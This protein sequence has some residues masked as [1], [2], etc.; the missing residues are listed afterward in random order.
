MYN[1][2]IVELIQLNCFYRQNKL[3]KESVETGYVIVPR[4]SVGCCCTIHPLSC[5]VN[6]YCVYMTVEVDIVL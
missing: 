5:K 2:H 4:W 6:P 3:G 1:Y